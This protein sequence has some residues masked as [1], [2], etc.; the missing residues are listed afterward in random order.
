MPSFSELLPK[1]FVCLLI[2]SNGLSLLLKYGTFH[3]NDAII[4]QPGITMMN[5]L[6]LPPTFLY[7]HSDGEV[8]YSMGLWSVIKKKKKHYEKNLVSMSNTIT[9]AYDFPVKVENEQEVCSIQW[10]TRSYG[11]FFLN[12]SFWNRLWQ[13]LAKTLKTVFLLCQYL[14]A[15]VYWWGPWRYRGNRQRR[16]DQMLLRLFLFFSCKEKKRKRKLYP[17]ALY[18]IFTGISATEEQFPMFFLLS[19]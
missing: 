15:K 4:H 3:W 2:S 9:C 7:R 16:W 6:K 12:L 14:P 19:P 1:L 11:F 18:Q 13:V 17:L 10:R 5:V 8:M